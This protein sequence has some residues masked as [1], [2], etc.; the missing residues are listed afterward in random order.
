MSRAQL[1]KMINQDPENFL[2]LC[3]EEIIGELIP[4][5]IEYKEKVENYSKVKEITDDFDISYRKASEFLMKK[6]MLID[7]VES[8][9][10]EIRESRKFHVRLIQKILSLVEKR[11][12]ELMSKSS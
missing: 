3:F 6:L 5:Y 1:N 7:K 4:L 11:K 10:E 12:M 2:S 8:Q 9:N